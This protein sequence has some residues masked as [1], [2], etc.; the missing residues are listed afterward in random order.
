MRRNKER[1]PE[2]KEKLDQANRRFRDAR[3][4]LELEG[5]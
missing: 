1:R 3:G 4:R 2:M 5:Q